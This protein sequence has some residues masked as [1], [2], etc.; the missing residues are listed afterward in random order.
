MYIAGWQ[1]QYSVIDQGNM[2]IK[3]TTE[4]STVLE[5]TKA[6]ERN[7]IAD[8]TSFFISL[9]EAQRELFFL[10]F[11]QNSAHKIT[12]C[13][14]LLSKISITKIRRRG[15]DISRA[16]EEL[17]FSEH[18]L[19]WKFFS[20]LFEE[21]DDS[22]TNDAFDTF[23]QILS[24][25]RNKKMAH[26]RDYDLLETSFEDYVAAAKRISELM[27]F[28]F[29]FEGDLGSSLVKTNMPIPEY[30]KDG[31]KFVGRTKDRREVRRLIAKNHVTCIAGRG[32]LGKTALAQC[33]VK[34]YE[35][36]GDFDY[37]IWFSCKTDK[38]SPSGI[39]EL[40]KFD[41]SFNRLLLN[42]IRVYE[43]DEMNYEDDGDREFM[44]NY[45]E[46]LVEPSDKLLI[47]LDNYETLEIVG[48]EDYSL[49]QQYLSD[50]EDLPFSKNVKWLLTSRNTLSFAATKTLDRL[51]D[52]AADKLLLQSI[53]KT[54]NF[55]S[56]VYKKTRKKDYRSALLKGLHNYPLYIKMFCG[57]LGLG[58]AIDDSLRVGENVEEL[59]EFCFRNTVSLLNDDAYSQVRRYL[60]FILETTEQGIVDLLP[61]DYCKS[62]TISSS[63][64]SDYH[65]KL[66]SLSVI[67]NS[68]EGGV[69]VAPAMAMYI[70]RQLR[71]DD[72]DV[73][74]IQAQVSTIKKDRQIRV[75]WL[76][77]EYRSEFREEYKEA[78]SAW[79]SVK[80]ISGSDLSQ[81]RL[82]NVKSRF[83]NQ[84]SLFYSLTSSSFDVSSIKDSLKKNRDRGDEWLCILVF[85]KGD[86]AKDDKTCGSGDNA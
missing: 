82:L 15:E 85:H 77:L 26:T 21:W 70:K 81:T 39:R 84:L 40:G 79:S 4:E 83:E 65:A 34:E 55:P 61:A 10:H 49:F 3:L 63:E 18:F 27:N 20:E 51:D 13:L 17:N 43:G 42:S 67:I 73:M 78:I 80:N 32:G 53:E 64:L 57:W 52:S 29:S 48:E 44:L 62:L 86:L 68:E 9:N 72:V 36:S 12:L 5:V 37:I 33:L 1:F 50:V 22:M 11:S 58:K 16:F 76:C 25:W 54:D 28:E 19:I 56:K 8:N 69:Q 30:E 46:D 35:N 24:T 47:V 2:R 59:E 74:E 23:L 14:D 75:E 45:L 38:M 6:F 31:G 7:C 66:T 41:S 60:L 71:K